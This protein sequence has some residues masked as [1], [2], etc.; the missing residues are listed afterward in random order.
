M[1]KIII[2]IILSIWIGGFCFFSY[3]INKMNIDNE[4]K[5]DAIIVLTGGRN[6]INEAITLFNNNF[7][8]SALF[9]ISL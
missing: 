5:T 8:F 9:K 3:K 4:Q 7:A 1:K 6:R 2:L